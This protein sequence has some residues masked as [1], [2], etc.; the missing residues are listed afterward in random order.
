MKQ[1][2]CIIIDDDQLAINVIENYI[3]KVNFLELKACFINPIEAVVYLKHNS[4]DL[5][6]VDIQM[7]G[8][9]GLDFIKIAGPTSKFIITSAYREFAFEGFELNVFDFLGKP[10]SF[11]RFLSGVTKLQN[12]NLQLPENEGQKKNFIFIKENRQMVKLLLED[13]L[14]LESKRDFVAFYCTTSSHQT[15]ST[16]SFFE[17]WLPKSDFTR[18]H[19]SFIVAISKIR[20]IGEQ[21]VTLQNNKTLPI[22]EFYEDGFKQVV[23]GFFV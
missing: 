9:T 13:I 12:N 18:I 3:G 2:K 19:R 1:I 8:I 23:K 21:Q 5:I 20:S 14:Y 16:L 17:D 4:V 7:P 22:G 15:R 6:F 10:F 11:E